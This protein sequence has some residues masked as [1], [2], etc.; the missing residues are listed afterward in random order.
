MGGQAEW[1]VLV[2]LNAKNNL[3]PFA[4]LNFDQLA[5]IGSTDEV[6]FIVEMGRPAN[7]YTDECGAWSKVLRFRVEQGQK[8]EEANKLEDLGA[9]NMG[10]PKTLLDFVTWGREKYPAKHTML[11]IWNHGQ[12]WRAP[13]STANVKHPLDGHPAGGYRYVSTD[14]DTGDKLYNRA[15]QDA[16]T[17]LLASNKLD[18]IAFDAC[19]MAMVE[20]AYA[21]RDLADVLVAS[22]ELEPGNGWNYTKWAQPLVA[23]KGAM[24]G[25][26][27][28]RRVVRAMA[29][30][31]GD[32]QD[33]TLSA[34]S[35]DQITTVSAALSKFATVAIPLLDAT[36]IGAFK[37]SRQ[38]CAG[39]A[40]VYNMQSIDIVKFMTELAKRAPTPGIADEC[41]NVISAVGNAVLDHHASK[42]RQGMYGSNGL[43]IYF[44]ATAAAKA[45]DPDGSGYDAGNTLHPVEFV[46]REQWAAFLRAY[47]K[48]VP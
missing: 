44:P 48:L 7:H 25:E 45:G 5:S 43:A 39:Y 47:W 10:D 12:G 22:E 24:T 30:T 40:H 41:Q 1:T 37:T 3:E 21:M 46:E 33:T 28:A 35:L 11:V 34:V 14:D 9:A 15:I 16:L 17:P 36:T 42:S 29:E 20:T 18:V 13:P 19:L 8:A 23:A 6:N 32:T 4:F 38:M 27:L 26:A 31:Y 2:F